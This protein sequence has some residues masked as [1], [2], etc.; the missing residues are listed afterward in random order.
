MHP[1]GWPS[2]RALPEAEPMPPVDA[3]GGG[4]HSYCLWLVQKDPKGNRV[5]QTRQVQLCLSSPRSTGVETALP[6]I[7]LLGSCPPHSA[8]EAAAMLDTSSQHQ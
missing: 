1:G 4:T 5:P 7:M 2:R 6:W 3:G 8:S